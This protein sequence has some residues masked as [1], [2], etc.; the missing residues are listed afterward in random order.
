[1]ICERCKQQ[2]AAIEFTAVVGD[3]K[4]TLHLCAEC[5]KA[6]S[7]S[8]VVVDIPEAKKG[9]TKVNVVVGHLADGETRKDACP[10]CGMT[11][12]EFRKIGR[13]GCS[14]CYDAFGPSLRRL[15]KRIHGSD[16]HVGREPVPAEPP[17]PSPEPTDA[18]GSDVEELRVA[19]QAAID[20]EEYELAAQLRDRILRLETLALEL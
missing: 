2:E 3:S 12:E 1:M 4:K 5:S 9:S 16:T 13:L 14:G 10:D 6:E 7:E 8:H 20:A 19:L 17:S 18:D 11:Y 15:L